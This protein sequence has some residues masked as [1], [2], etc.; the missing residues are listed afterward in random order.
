[1]SRQCLECH[2][3]VDDGIGFCEACGSGSFGYRSREWPIRLS[4]IAGVLSILLFLLHVGG[5]H[6]HLVR[7]VQTVGIRF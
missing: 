7:L 2:S 1:M 3:V 5:I 4:A 6:F